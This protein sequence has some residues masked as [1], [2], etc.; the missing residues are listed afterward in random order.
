MANK[1][2]LVTGVNSYIGKNFIDYISSFDDY[3]VEAI[4]VRD[5]SWKDVDF[6]QYDVV[7]DALFDGDLYNNAYQRA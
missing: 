7:Y 6:G 5:D 4:S 3:S 1:K 2:I